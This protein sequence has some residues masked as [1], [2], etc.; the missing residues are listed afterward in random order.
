MLQVTVET[1][2]KKKKRSATQQV[3]ET[4]KTEATFTGLDPENEY[5]ITVESVPE[6]GVLPFTAV[7]RLWTLPRYMMPPSR[8]KFI[9]ATDT[10]ISVMLYAIDDYDANIK[11]YQVSGCHILISSVFSD[12]RTVSHE[13]NGV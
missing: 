9:N 5:K 10:T 8:P 13:M 11:G 3:L 1:S 2:Y 12:E 7:T 4:T 6:E